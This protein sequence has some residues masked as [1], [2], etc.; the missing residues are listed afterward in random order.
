MDIEER[1]SEGVW[2]CSPY[3]FKNLPGKDDGLRKE[4][5]KEGIFFSKALSQCIFFVGV[6]RIFPINRL[7]DYEEEENNYTD[8]TTR[9]LC[10]TLGA[11]FCFMGVF[12]LI[13]LVC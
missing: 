7:E 10:Y 8:S 9:A 2:Y 13:T 3:D 11:L 1:D 4:N 6:I 5:M 12:S